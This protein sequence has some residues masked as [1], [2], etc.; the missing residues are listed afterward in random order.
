MGGRRAAGGRQAGSRRAAGGRQATCW[1]VDRAYGAPSV[2]TVA[3]A[4]LVGPAAQ[5]GGLPY[6][7]PHDCILWG[8]GT[9]T[10]W[11]ACLVCLACK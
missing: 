3:G 4:V 5:G 6:R 10:V 2:S 1:A 7:G 8:A 9:S 11:A